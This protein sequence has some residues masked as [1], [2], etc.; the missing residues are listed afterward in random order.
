M[1]C[2]VATLKLVL[3]CV[4]LAQCARAQGVAPAPGVT[5]P[6]RVRQSLDRMRRFES[7]HAWI[8]KTRAIRANREKFIEDRGFYKRELIPAAARS[9]LEVRGT[10]SVPVFCVKYSDVGADPFPI[11][12]LQTRLFDGPYSPRTLTQFYDENSHGDLHVTGTVYGW[13]SLPQTAVYYAGQAMC[14]GLC[15][16]AR[17]T[18]LIA[19]TIS[20]N[21]SSID[22]GQYDNDGPD[23]IPNS[24]DDDGFVDF[25]S[26]VHSQLGAECDVYDQ[27][28]S[29]CYS[30]AGWRSEGVGPGPYTTNDARTGGGFIKVDDYTI[31]P[32]LNCDNTTMIDIGVFCHEFGHTFGLPDLYDTDG[33]SSGVGWWDLM[34]AGNWNQPDNPAYMGAWSKNFLGW[35]NVIVAPPEPT[36]YA[37]PDAEMNRE[38]YRLDVVHE[39]WRRSTLCP[40]AGAYSMHC[41]LT[42]AEAAGRNWENS[43]VSGYGDDWDTR[44]SREFNYGGSGSVS[45]QYQYR[46]EF[47]YTYGQAPPNDFVYGEVTSGGTTS[48]FATYNDN[49]GQTSGTQTVDLT[50]YLSP[51]PYTVAFHLVSDGWYSDQSGVG[52]QCGAISLDDISVT[53]G[54]ESYFTDFE[55]REDG[56]AE[57]MNPPSEYFLVENRKPIGSD[58]NIPGTAPGG[59]LVVW[60]IE[61]NTQ[62]GGRF[63]NQPR[64]VAVV[65]ADHLAQLEGNI[66]RGDDGDPYPGTTGNDRLD[67]ASSPSS[68]GYDGPSIVS[69][70]LTGPNADPLNATLAGGWPAPV[71]V[72]VTPNAATGTSVTLQVDGALFA[73]GG[74]VQLVH[75]ARTFGATSVYWAGKDRVIARFDL[76]GGANG[77]YD[78]VAFNPGGASAALPQAFTLSG[79][80]AVTHPAPRRFAL[81]PAYPSPFRETATLRYELPAHAH[82]VLRVYDVNGAVV[83]TLVD[84]EQPAGAY[85]L[86]WNGRDDEGRPA[87]PGVYFD[88]ITAGGFSDVRKLT[89]VK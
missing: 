43:N 46:F 18:E 44:V 62:S 10:L 72:S 35:S 31:E 8:A 21:D 53:G 1:R 40:I 64:G 82:V 79:S 32:A 24:G 48:V 36:P 9:E 56:W 12:Q 87:G 57:E 22:F 17:I 3:A 50:P 20:A 37:I 7:Q 81:L 25:V 68:D 38:A 89:L 76:T 55:T 11:A 26:F 47:T 45:L 73:K 67:G 27:I 69:V 52:T 60:H 2:S 59:G 63:D 4:V 5:M 41:G 86:R 70:R 65:Q 42:S 51:G 77:A 71:P 75:G 54:G 78:V 58:V 14:Q 66:N 84:D 33:G 28:W 16:S 61:Q 13:T 39:R 49:Q 83:R 29:H 85:A 88:R 30:L 15:S 6:P 23:G 80:V 19:T 34:G 74:G